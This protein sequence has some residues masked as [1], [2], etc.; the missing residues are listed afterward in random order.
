[1]PKETSSERMTA[2]AQLAMNAQGP[3]SKRM[4]PTRC[5]DA[6]RREGY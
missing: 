6:P 3:V 5:A 4:C 1:M 2:Q